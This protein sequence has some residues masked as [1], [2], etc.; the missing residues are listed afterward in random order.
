MNIF[1]IMQKAKNLKSEMEESQK[2]LAKIEVE[3]RSGGGMVVVSMACD[4]RVISVKLDESIKDDLSMLED[5][6]KLAMNDALS[7]VSEKLQEN[8]ASQLGGLG[9]PPDFKLPF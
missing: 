6:L 5:L 1:E 4:Y 7:K 2:K 3:G 9:L 8:M